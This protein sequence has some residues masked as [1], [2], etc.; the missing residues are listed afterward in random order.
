MNKKKIP[1]SFVLIRSPN[2]LITK[3]RVLNIQKNIFIELQETSKN[4]MIGHAKILTYII[5]KNFLT[6]VLAAQYQKAS[7]MDEAP[8]S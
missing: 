3:D 5:S 7:G 4:L 2:S 8:F 6:N 1:F